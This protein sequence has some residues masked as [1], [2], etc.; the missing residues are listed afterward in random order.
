MGKDYYKLLGVDRKATEEEI[1]K[2]YK[3]LA[4]KTHPDKAPEAERKTAEKKF[5]EIGEAAEVL[6]DKQKR[7]VYD[8]F[9][10]E[11]LKGGGA[12]P[13]GAGGGGGGFP[14]GFGGPGGTTFSFSGMPGGGSGGF[15]P[16][17]PNDIF[18]SI[19]GAM[20]G[21]GDPFGGMGG[22]GGMGGGGGGSSRTRRGGGGGGGGM[23]GMGGMG[24]MGG[25]PGMG[26]MGGMGMGGMPGG[27]GDM[28][29]DGGAPG[30]GGGGG[31]PG[32]PGGPSAPKDFEKKLPVTLEDLYKG[33]RKKLKI[34]KRTLS[35]GTEEN[36]LEVDVKAGWKSGTKIRFGGKGNDLPSG[37]AQDLVFIIEEKPH[38]RF[39]RQGDDL[40]VTSPLSLVDALDPP[41]VGGKRAVQT[42][43]GRTLS[44]PMPTP[45]PGKTTIAN[46]RT[47]RVQGEGMPISKTPGKKGDLIIEWNVEVPERLSDE[48]RRQ[49][50]SALTL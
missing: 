27:F 2:A 7:A 42:L 29:M 9:G 5:Q 23:P 49:I 33:A 17:D 12:P 50:R 1:K 26:G 10:E 14:P 18:A 39:T 21:G 8:Q 41:R 31:R 24:G 34:G 13:P 30:G 20:G 19:F 32:S 43:D 3:K 36:I 22:M 40:K 47:T 35:G 6:S 15:T 28:D 44:V 46:G 38:A 48:Q 11:G 45:Q 25:M 37:G 4:L 16:S